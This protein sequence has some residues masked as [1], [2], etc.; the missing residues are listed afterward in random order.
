MK[1]WPIETLGNVCKLVNGRAFKPHE[2]EQSGTPIIRI[3]NLNDSTKPFNYTTKTFPENF[4]V[5]RGDILLSWSGTPGTSFG[6]FRWNGP[7]GWL[8]QHIFNVRLYE[9]V[10]PSF[11]IYQVNSKL[12]ELIARAHGGVGLQ[13]IT[14]G[15][16][17]SVN[18]TVPPLTEQERIVHILDEA[19]ELRK[20]R[21]QADRRTADLIPAL[22]HE[23]FGDGQLF[24]N[25][26]LIEL[27]D[28]TR[29]ISYGV[30]Q[31]GNHFHGGV[32]L[33]R[34]ADFG[35]N[36]FAPLNLVSV[37]PNISEQYRRTVLIGGELVISIRGTVGRVA[38]VPAASSGWNVAREVAVI[39]LLP[40]IS[41][42]FLHTYLL[43][44]FAQ[45]FITNEVR[46]IAQRG[47]NLE[48]L[49]R[50]PVPIPPLSLQN[51]FAQRVNEIREMEADQA[52]SKSRL[53]ALFHSLLHRAFEGEL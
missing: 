16:L 12:N 50:L 39:P 24:P 11:F 42:P 23:M 15:A 29:G 14:R 28:K 35:K 8:N 33:L 46:G 34:I 6:C 40:N 20:L 9:E 36:F 41:R 53:N 1:H 13:H 30:V 22:F 17:S 49:R 2:W 26:P 3:Q 44:S 21:A 4:R 48:D 47:I 7:D 25:K 27:V 43:S 19:D 18:I 52:K 38:I 10:L 5:K 32:P 51:E 37:D 45:N 31:R